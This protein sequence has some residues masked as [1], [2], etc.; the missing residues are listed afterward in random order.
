MR[1]FLLASVATLGT[2]GLTG[3]ALA[4]TPP[5]APVPAPLSSPAPMGGK[6]IGAPTQGQ[7][8][9]SPAPAPVSYANTNNNY[10]APALP[11]ALANPTPGTIV[12]HVNGKVQSS[13]SGSWS[14]LDRA[15]AGRPDAKIQPVNI[16]SF[17]RT[18]FGGDAM[19]TNG[20]RYGAAI[21]IR[22]NFGTQGA[23]QGSTGG[24]AYL[25]TQTTYIRRGFLYV[26]GEEWGI[27]RFG[28]GDGPISIFDNGVTTF[29]FLPSGVFNGGD[30]EAA[31]P[32]NALVTSP[33]LSQSGNEYGYSKAVYLSPQMAGFDFGF[34]YAP[35]TTNGYGIANCTV[36]SSGCPNLSSSSLVADASRLMN[37]TEAGVRYQGIFGGVG[38]LAYGVWM[39]SGVVNYTG[40]VAAAR[41]VGASGTPVGGTFTG[42][43]DGVNL[44]SMG[45]AATFAG[46]TAGGN[47]IM[48]RVNG[49]GAADPQGGVNE[50]GYLV[51]TKYVAGP[52]TI[53]AAFENTTSQ[54]AVQLTGISQRHE[55][56]FDTGLSYALAPGLTVWAEYV[57]QQRH[58]G[59]F[60]FATGATAGPTAADFNDTKAQGAL[61]GTV[62]NF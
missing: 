3:A 14:N 16:N 6:T 42:R 45:L 13:I 59:G 22:N 40:S 23:S 51:G 35:S 47:V 9:W 43:F 36:A 12:V 38:V 26:A 11:G 33:F 32:S 49:L 24:S 27:V 5:G 44:G 54:G 7:Q 21:E 8:A 19:A 56:A 52:L 39:H 61:F 29:Q 60:N 58:Q 48:G 37:I 2:G 18:Y 62:V 30:L 17:A 15:P 53:G 31:F 4:Q 57:Y 55:W 1:K 20:L 46:F 28:G 41:G 10:Q 50:I 34:S 25:G